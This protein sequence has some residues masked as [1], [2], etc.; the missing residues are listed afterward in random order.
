MNSVKKNGEVGV[1][2]WISHVHTLVTTILTEREGDTKY[3]PGD[4]GFSM[5]SYAE[6]PRKGMETERESLN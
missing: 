5:F 6:D 4:T 1:D 2:C 3:Y